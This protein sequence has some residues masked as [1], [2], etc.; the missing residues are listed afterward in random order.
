MPFEGGIFQHDPSVIDFAY[1]LIRDY[2][3]HEREQDQ[4]V[5]HMNV[6]HKMRSK[7]TN[8]NGWFYGKYGAQGIRVCPAW[9]SSLDKFTED[10][11]PVPKG[12]IGLKRLD[13][14]K[15]FTQENTVWRH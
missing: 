12:A 8:V 6:W 11:G 14:T 2:E 3:E 15:H 10:M 4:A 9:N 7:C 1:Q 5:T 13:P